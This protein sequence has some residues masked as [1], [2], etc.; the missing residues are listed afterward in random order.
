MQNKQEKSPQELCSPPK[1]SLVF[2]IGVVGHR[3]DR[4]KSADSITLHARLKEIITTAQSQ[5]SKHFREHHAF[6]DDKQPVVRAISPLAEGVDRFFAQQALDAGCELTAVLPFI[7]EE[8]Q[9]DF[10]PGTALEKDSLTT[11]IELLSKATTIFELDGQRNDDTRAY[12]VAGDVV[13]NQSDLLIVVW[14]GERQNKRG[15]TEQ[16]LDDAISRG[17]PIVWIDAHAPHHWKLVTKPLCWMEEV[18]SDVRAELTKSGAIDEIKQQVDRL[19]QLPQP[20]ESRDKLIP[21]TADPRKELETYYQERRPSWRLGI[22]WKWFRNIIGD[23]KLKPPPLSTEPYEWQLAEDNSWPWCGEHPV[24]AMIDTLRPYFAWADK[25]AAL[26]ADAYRSAFVISF[27]LAALSVA[28]ALAAVGLHLD[29]HSKGELVFAV[30][31]LVMIG[32]IL[33]LV[34]RGRRARWHRRWLDYR[35]LAEMIR[36]QRLVTHLGSQRATPQ[37]PEHLTSYGDP[38]SSWMAWYARAVERSLGL[39]TAV[40]DVAYLHRSLEDQYAILKEQIDFHEESQHHAEHIEHRLHWIELGLLG[41]TLF[42]CLLH[43]TQ[44]IYHHWPHVPSHVLTF[45]CGFLPAMGAALAG[46]SNQ[47]EFRRIS[48]RSKSMRDYLKKQIDR[49]VLLQHS[50]ATSP[51]TRQLSPDVAYIASNTAQTL[52]K[53]VLDWRIIFQDQPLRTV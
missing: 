37:V 30:F 38:G 5:V 12:H 24:D 41:A 4:L 31:E 46:I 21:P 35:L 23:G 36:H 49:V 10:E 7:R 8:C 16:T 14:D 15:G 45:F 50:L 28:M 13:L 3:P 20:E 51:L 40:V 44:G 29:P 32:T 39:P 18:K 17:V 34:V 11:F 53:E 47:A 22:W 33:V 27:F 1:P 26:Y 9:H 48:Q 42:C 52:T 19:L 2:R 25:T 6:Y 43:I